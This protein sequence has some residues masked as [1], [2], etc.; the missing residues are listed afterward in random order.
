LHNL[1]RVLETEELLGISGNSKPVGEML[2]RALGH[3][4]TSIGEEIERVGRR[5][6]RIEQD[7][8]A[9]KERQ[10]VR[11]ISNTGRVLLRFETSLARHEEPLTEFLAG[12]STSSL[13]GTYFEEHAAKIA[14]RRA[15]AKSLASSY[16]EIAHELRITNDSLLNTSQNEVMKILTI[17]AFVTFPLSLIASVF[18]MNTEYLP[19]VGQPGDFWIVVGIMV[20]LTITFFAYF[21]MKRW[22]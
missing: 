1:Q 11:A 4:Y 2:E 22:L 6:E 18:G 19:F 15:H 7:I 21:R 14:S 8:F 9:G 3:L 5:L 13:L 12:L 16:R 17:M 20:A 10:M